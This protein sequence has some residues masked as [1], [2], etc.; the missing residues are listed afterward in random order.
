M[1]GLV[2]TTTAIPRGV[3]DI[4]ASVQQGLHNAP[5]VYG[6]KVR[7]PGKVTDFTSGVKEAG[8]GL[9]Y[10]YYDGITG[11]VREPIQGAKKGGFI[12]AIK[13]S[14]RSF[15]NVTLR[16]AAGIIG[17]VTHPFHGAM[18]SL[19]TATGK[20]QEHQIRATRIS[21]GQEAVK[22]STAMQRAEIFRK[23]KEA[24]RDTQARQKKYKEIV[25][26]VMWEDDE[27]SRKAKGASEGYSDYKKSRKAKG[28]SE[29]YH[30][31]RKSRK[32]K[33]VSEE[34]PD[35]EESNA[36]GASEGYYDYKATSSSSQT[37]LDQDIGT[38]STTD[39][40]TEDV[41]AFERELELAK[42]L[43]LAEQ[44]GYERG[45]ASR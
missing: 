7:Q 18:R 40:Q 1:D 44:R 39:S 20:Q 6:S 23:F 22:N 36:K 31:H 34:L 32:A 2:R 27:E 42:Q 9:F 37:A 13:G 38:S 4:V 29:G 28:A 19:Q 14:A 45:L 10:G 11:L 15:V 35:Y 26:K 21:D 33:G 43:S 12:G 17:V 16:P 25:E 24:Q 8:K 41:A 30:D 3:V 5:R